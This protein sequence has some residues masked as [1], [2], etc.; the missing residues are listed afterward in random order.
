M[1]KG[2]RESHRGRNLAL[3]GSGI[4]LG[5]AL[6]GVLAWRLRKN[7]IPHMEMTWDVNVDPGAVEHAAG[8]VAVAEVTDDV[9]RTD[10][11]RLMLMG[12]ETAPF[13]DRLAVGGSAAIALRD[14]R[15]GLWRV[16]V[17]VMNRI[18]CLQQ[19]TWHTL[20]LLRLCLP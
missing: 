16:G 11:N 15:T 6:V 14:V 10:K 4:A 19:R 18:V 2:G 7:R 13:A 3:A 20:L 12:T 8:R 17:V 5:A 1:T 9:D